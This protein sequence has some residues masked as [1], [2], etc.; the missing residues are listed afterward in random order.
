MFLLSYLKVPERIATSVLYII[1]D[2][3]PE[4]DKQIKYNRR[5]Q[6]KK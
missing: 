5:A 3:H 6:S 2:V 4:G 1:F